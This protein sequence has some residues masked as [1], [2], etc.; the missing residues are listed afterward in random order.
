MEAS[1]LTIKP[2]VLPTVT[3]PLKVVWKDNGAKLETMGDFN[4]FVGFKV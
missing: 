4:N 2:I 3:M 1:T